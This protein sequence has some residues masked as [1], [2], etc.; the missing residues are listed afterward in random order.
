MFEESIHMRKIKLAI[1]TTYPPGN[2]TLNEYAYHFVRFLR[3]KNDVSEIILLTDELPP[4][5][6]YTGESLSAEKEVPLRIIPC[7]RFGAWN[8][9]LRILAA[10]RACKPDA[11]L[12][13][14]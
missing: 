4:G 3:K 14:L 11:V 13:N 9:P 8:N 6:H 1:V 5:Q 12:F 2:G 10:I 7:W